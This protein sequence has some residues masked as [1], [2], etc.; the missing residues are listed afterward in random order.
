[1]WLAADAWCAVKNKTTA[2]GDGPI[3]DINSSMTSASA[4]SA[5]GCVEVASEALSECGFAMS[6]Q[7]ARHTKTPVVIIAITYPI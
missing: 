3:E 6:I 1:M 2:S 4:T 7:R 5:S